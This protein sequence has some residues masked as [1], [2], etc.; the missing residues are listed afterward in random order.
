IWMGNAWIAGVMGSARWVLTHLDLASWKKGQP[1]WTLIM[2]VGRICVV[3]DGSEWRRMAA[4]PIED[5][6]APF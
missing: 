6:G 2:G 3:E 4:V 5:G 1:W